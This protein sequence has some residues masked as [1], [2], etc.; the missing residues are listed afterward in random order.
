M[1]VPEEWQVKSLSTTIHYMEMLEPGSLCPK[2]APDGFEVSLVQPPS[3]ALSKQ[4]Y[5]TVG[6]PWEWNERLKWTDDQWARHVNRPAVETWVGSLDGGSVGY[7]E[8]ESQADGNVEIRYFGLLAEYIGRG[9]GGALLRAAVE[10]AWSTDDTRRVW[11]H[12]CTKDHP[13]ALE[14][15]RRRGFRVYKT[16]ISHR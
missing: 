14:N 12:T 3:P 8:L 13:L 15:Y 6:G 11:V 16:S 9:L 5:Q 10:R 7:F 4:F 2:E 1:S